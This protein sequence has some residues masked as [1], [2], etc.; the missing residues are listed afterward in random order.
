MPESYCIFE[1]PALQERLEVKAP[2]RSLV[3][4]EE[5]RQGIGVPSYVDLGN[6]HMMKT[7]LILWASK[8][9][10]RLVE[11]TIGQQL[12]VALFGGGAFKLHCPS[13]NKGPLCRKIGD[14]DFVTLKE[15]GRL[16]V[17]V[18]CNLDKC[19]SM[20]F[21]GLSSADK[22]LA[23]MRAGTRFRLHTIRDIDEQGVPIPGLMDI[24]CDDLTFCHTVSIRDELDEVERNCFTI[25]LE[26]LIIS[27]AQLIKSVSK[28]EAAELDKNRI[29]G[30]YDKKHLLAGMEIKDMQDV[31]AALCDHDLGDGVDKISVDVLGRKLRKDWRMWKTVT[32]NLR[33]M[34][35]KSR[36]LTDVFG[37]NKEQRELVDEKLA[38]II[39]QLDGKYAAKRNF[40]FTKQWWED[41]EE[42]FT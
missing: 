29:L 18:L 22:R 23:L 41:V 39:E 42:Q 7:V 26:N 5:L 32:M 14:V 30:E 33:N 10:D 35:H 2:L 20:F 24:F 15:H 34:R 9:P 37:A 11:G 36:L 4:I 16:L 3:N 40:T 25:G 31:A 28:D 38:R 12:S 13:A 17:K 27:K 6:F 1:N 21:H 19:G 8:H